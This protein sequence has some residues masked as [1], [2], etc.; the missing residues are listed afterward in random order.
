MRV[1]IV[2]DEVLIAMQLE[3]IVTQLGHEV[4]AIA[5]SASQALARAAALAPDIAL[6]DIRLSGG[7]CGIEAARDLH[8]LHGIRCVF[9]SA[10]LDDATRAAV[11]MYD[12]I[13][14][15]GKPF[16]PVRVQQA[17][18]KAADGLDG[19]RPRG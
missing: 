6:M 5:A 8:A 15:V 7:S 18:E 3:A 1:L 10:N 19:R 2:E 14:F 4:C 12:P 17:L 13:D 9:L 16:V 11:Q